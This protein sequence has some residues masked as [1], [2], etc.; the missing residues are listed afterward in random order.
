M[1][2]F[3]PLLAVTRMQAGNVVEYHYTAEAREDLRR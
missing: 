2:V 1:G 3:F